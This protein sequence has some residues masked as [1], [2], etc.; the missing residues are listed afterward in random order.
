MR[1]LSKFFENPFDDRG[2]SMDELLAFTT[3]NIARMS[4]NNGSGELTA[5]ITATQSGL[6][7]VME[8]FS[9]DNTKL[10]LRKARKMVKDD[11]R[12]ELPAKVGKLAVKVEDQYGEKSP[13]FVECFPQ[14][15]AVF[16]KA[17]DDA[18]EAHIQTLIDGLT[19][20]QTDLGAQVVTD[21]TALKTGWLAVYAPSEA[22][23][24]AK[25][26]TQDEK[27]Y[28]RENLQLMLFL[29][30]VKYMEMHPREPEKLATYMTQSLLEDHPRAKDEPAPAPAPTP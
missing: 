8:R 11:F 5:R 25:S 23:S 12:K 17:T 1:N 7:L 9:D 4:A 16:G 27:K 28:A 10:A 19:A 29:N 15:R 6:D 24:A 21:A 26:A 13:Q 20:H 30:L 14:G 3:D 22:A 2:I 18:L